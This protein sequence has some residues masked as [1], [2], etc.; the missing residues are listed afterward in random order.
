MTVHDDAHRTTGRTRNSEIPYRYMYTNMYVTVVRSHHR[1]P[2][3][4]CWIV[5]WL[6]VLIGSRTETKD[7]LDDMKN[8]DKGLRI[9]G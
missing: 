9:I 6:H 4:T 5:L 7:L 2:M 1:R 3:Q 8:S